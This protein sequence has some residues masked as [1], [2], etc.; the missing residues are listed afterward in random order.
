MSSTVYRNGVQPGDT[1]VLKVVVV[2]NGA[3]LSADILPKESDYEIYIRDALANSIEPIEAIRV[4]DTGS[5]IE[6]RKFFM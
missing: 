4:Y 3:E 1:D 2:K 5:L 6:E